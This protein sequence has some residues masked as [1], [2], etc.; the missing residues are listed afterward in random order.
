MLGAQAEG[1]AVRTVEDLAADAPLPAAL[2]EEGMRATGAEAS[3]EGLDDLQRAFSQ[4]HGLQCGYCTPG[5]L[6][7]LTAALAEDPDLDRHPDR[8][9]EW[10]SSNLCRCTGYVGIR[11]AVARVC[12]GNAARH[13]LRAKSLFRAAVPV[14][15]DADPSGASHRRPEYPAQS[16]LVYSASVTCSPQVGGPWVIVRWVMK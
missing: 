6:M 3:L 1:C 14:A 7:L 16:L 12:A 13:R 8:L 15:S 5:F 2:G 11:R 10:L 9:D 4:E